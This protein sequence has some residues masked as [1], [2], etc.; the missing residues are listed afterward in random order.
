MRIEADPGASPR[1]DNPTMPETT[2]ACSDSATSRQPYHDT[3]PYTSLRDCPLSSP[4]RTAAA[5][6]LAPPRFPTRQHVEHVPPMSTCPSLSEELERNHQFACNA[7]LDGDYDVAVQELRRDG[8]SEALYDRAGA[9]VYARVPSPPQRR[10][11]F[12]A[13]LEA[14]E[15]SIAGAR[16]QGCADTVELIWERYEYCLRAVIWAWEDAIAQVTDATER[17]RQDCALESYRAEVEAWDEMRAV[18][19]SLAK[20]TSISVRHVLER[21]PPQSLALVEDLDLV[22]K[23]LE[24]ADLDALLKALS[25]ALKLADEL[26]LRRLDL[27][28]NRIGD[29]GLELLCRWLGEYAAQLPLLAVVAVANNDAEAR[30]EVQLAATLSRVHKR[31]VIEGQFGAHGDERRYR[32]ARRFIDRR[33]FS[34]AELAPTPPAV[35]EGQ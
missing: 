16:E 13:A 32:I 22:D 20:A 31:A 7:I 15:R 28:H 35:A 27:S 21:C 23:A 11:A 18:K 4:G 14:L 19:A 1:S 29:R 2:V 24:P 10:E 33:N 25:K 34:R 3:I 26:P 30:T 5:R 6:W 12:I 17:T 8:S 9:M